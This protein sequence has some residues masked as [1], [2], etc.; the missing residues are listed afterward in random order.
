[1]IQEEPGFIVG[2]IS[3][4]FGN[5]LNIVFKAAYFF[6]ENYSLAIAIILLTIVARFLMMPLALK[7][8]KSMVVMRKIQPQ[9]KKIQNKYKDS[10][11]DPEVKRKMNVEMQ[12]LYSEHKYN[13]FSGCLPLLIQLPIFI[14]L[15]YVMQNPFAYISEIGGVYNEISSVIVENAEQAKDEGKQIIQLRNKPEAE[16]SKS[17]KD[18]FENYKEQ[19]G[20]TLDGNFYVFWYDFTL[21]EV[22]PMTPEDM[23]LDMLNPEDMPKALDKLNTEQWTSIAEH[24]PEG[25]INEILNRKQRIESFILNINLTEVS[26]FAWPGLLIPVLSGITTFLSSWLMMRKNQS[27]EP[28][29]QT[30]QKVMT[31]TMPLIMAWITS[32]L[33]CG[34]GLYWITSNVFQIGQQQLMNSYYEKKIM[35]DGSE[36]SYNNN[37]INE[38]TADKSS[39]RNKG[40]KKGGR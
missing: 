16:L 26:T 7:Q 32:S 12:K 40:G 6:T 4:I 37:I 30:Q 24:L 13:P 38:P 34:V 11:N 22:N 25:S 5:I 3:W 19:Y 31:I 10:M 28:A 21:N 33:P 39:K 17:E 35:G 18:A 29:M 1:M 36:K 20:E 15:Y 2:P 9:I 27:S 14:A 23:P 8:Q